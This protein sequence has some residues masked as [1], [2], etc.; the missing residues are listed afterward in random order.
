LKSIKGIINFK[1]IQKKSLAIEIKYVSPKNLDISESFFNEIQ[2]ELK[3]VDKTTFSFKQVDDIPKT[4][5]GKA[6]WIEVQK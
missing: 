4:I 1:V 5:A 6:K 3:D 2:K